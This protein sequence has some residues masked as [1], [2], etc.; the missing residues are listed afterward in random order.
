MTKKFTSLLVYII[1]CVF[2]GC[3][4]FFAV[5]SW[6][7]DMKALAQFSLALVGLTNV[8]GSASVQKACCITKPFTAAFGSKGVYRIPKPGNVRFEFEFFRK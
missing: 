3:L 6:F 1:C 7:L 4:F 5:F 2:D 8:L